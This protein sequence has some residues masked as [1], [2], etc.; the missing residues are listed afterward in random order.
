VGRTR[1]RLVGRR[2]GAIGAVNA[3]PTVPDCSAL[4]ERRKEVAKLLG[5]PSLSL[6][7]IETGIVDVHA[8]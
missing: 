3:R 2:A 6:P 8:T 4:A 1:T 5:S 7:V